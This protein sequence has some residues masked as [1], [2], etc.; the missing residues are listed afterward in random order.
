MRKLI[1]S[2]LC[3]DSGAVALEYA[4]IA[5]FLSV[6]ILGGVTGVA[7]K[8]SLRYGAISSVLP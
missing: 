3:A 7:A 2:F 1:H 8:V 5:G 4:L 6:V